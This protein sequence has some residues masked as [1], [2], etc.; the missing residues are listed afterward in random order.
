MATTHGYLVLELDQTSRIQGKPMKTTL[1]TGCGNSPRVGIVNELVLAW[2][3]GDTE[4][5]TGWLADDFSWTVVGSREL[6]GGEV[7]RL[8]LSPEHVE[9]LATITHGRLA[10]CDGYMT[11]DAARIDFCHTFRFAST[12]KAAKVSE[13]RTYLGTSTVNW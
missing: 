7:P 4:A 13:I 5:V 12:S 10:A 9:I 1:P 3:A 2:V 6:S 8:P 11:D